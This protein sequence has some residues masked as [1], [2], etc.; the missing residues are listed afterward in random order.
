M[1]D[2]MRDLQRTF[3]V[4]N[5][6]GRHGPPNVDYATAVGHLVFIR[7]LTGVIIIQRMHNTQI[8]KKFIQ[9]LGGGEGGHTRSLFSPNTESRMPHS[10]GR[11]LQ[12]VGTGTL[13][14]FSSLSTLISAGLPS[15]GGSSGGGPPLLPRSSS[16]SALTSSIR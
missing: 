10:P 4:T 7:V 6:V 11:M 12:M 3:S 13:I 1:K 15:L 8:E 5:S 16:S 14:S 2:N 9:D